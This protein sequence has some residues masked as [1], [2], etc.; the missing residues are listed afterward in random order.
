MAPPRQRAGEMPA[1]HEPECAADRRAAPEETLSR[2]RGAVTPLGTAESE[3]LLGQ[4]PDST[5]YAV[6][7]N[8]RGLRTSHSWADNGGWLRW[9]H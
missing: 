9:P 5:F 7:I 1:E 4:C 8:W 6:L 3:P 2:S